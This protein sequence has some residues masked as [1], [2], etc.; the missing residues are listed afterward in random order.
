MK[1]EHSLFGT[2]II[3]NQLFY[4]TN[5]AFHLV[6][7]DLVVRAICDYT[8]RATVNS[9]TIFILWLVLKVNNDRYVCLCKCWHICVLKYCMKEDGRII[10][11]G[12]A[13]EGN[14]ERLLSVT[15]SEKTEGHDLMVKI[16]TSNLSTIK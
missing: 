2:A 15:A 7:I 13:E 14:N 4:V 5:F 12:F 6:S 3:V 10:H 8:A 9:I 11:Q 16:V 1:K